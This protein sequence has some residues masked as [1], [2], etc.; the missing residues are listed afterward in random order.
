MEAS[1]NLMSLSLYPWGESP[2]CRLNR[3]PGW[4]S[5]PEWNLEEYEPH[6]LLGFQIQTVHS[7]VQL[8]C[9]LRYLEFPQNKYTIHIFLWKYRSCI[10][11]LRLWKKVSVQRHIPAALPLT[12]LSEV[13]QKGMCIT[14]KIV[15]SFNCLMSEVV[16]FLYD[17]KVY[18]AWRYISTHW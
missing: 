2:R 9:W 1:V 13:T 10:F 16:V 15:L 14:L 5:A 6:A 11:K 12:Q 3:T 18:G 4:A 8:P 17:M 7:V